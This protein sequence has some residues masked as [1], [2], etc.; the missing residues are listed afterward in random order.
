M[1]SSIIKFYKNRFSSFTAVGGRKSMY[2]GFNSLLVSTM[3]DGMSFTAQCVLSPSLPCFAPNV[4][5]TLLEYDGRL[6]ATLTSSHPFNVHIITRSHGSVTSV[7]RTT[8]Q[9]NGSRAF[10]SVQF[11]WRSQGGGAVGAAAS[12]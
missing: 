8:R 1:C 2:D 7:V 12:P 9:V 6:R 3:L 5:S 11:Q 4:D 10:F